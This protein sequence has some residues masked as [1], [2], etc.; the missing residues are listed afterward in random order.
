MHDGDTVFALATGHTELP[1]GD[2]DVVFRSA[3]G[4]PAA[5]NRLLASAAEVFAR[6]CARAV[7]EARTLP[8][9]PPCYLD[10]C[11]SARP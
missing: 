5:V 8:G 4:R 6:A 7:V 11:P 3:S 10:L 1:A 2:G 9:G